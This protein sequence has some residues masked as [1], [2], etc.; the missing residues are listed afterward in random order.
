MSDPTPEH[1]PTA[2]VETAELSPVASAG[3]DP[4]ESAAI[5]RDPPAAAQVPDPD[6]VHEPGHVVDGARHAATETFEAQLPTVDP[7]RSSALAQP[8]VIDGITQVVCPQCATVWKGDQLRPHAAWFCQQCQFPLFWVNAGIRR[9]PGST[10]EALARLP[11]TNGRTAL[12]AIN[13][14]WCGEHNPP[15]PTA[16]CLRCHRPLTV[17]DPPPPMVAPGA[18]D[19]RRADDRAAPTADLAMGRRHRRA[20]ARRADPRADHDLQ[21]LTRRP[22]G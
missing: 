16:N 2:T 11:G 22:P 12:S 15:D 9:E 17:P 3:A 7:D 14:P 4:V 19:R 1:E 10:E 20:L 18:G 21:R 13:C 5:E 6:E 8:Q